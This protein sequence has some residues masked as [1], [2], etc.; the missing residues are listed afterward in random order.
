MGKH[1]A[2]ALLRENIGMRLMSWGVTQEHLLAP[3]TVIVIDPV[4]GVFTWREPTFVDGFLRGTA[5]AAMGAQFTGGVSSLDYK[6]GDRSMTLVGER[7]DLSP[8]TI[9]ITVDEIED[10]NGWH[11]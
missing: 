2:R 10:I 11:D 5:W 3:V 7:D 6:A 8:V 1:E 4:A 9:I